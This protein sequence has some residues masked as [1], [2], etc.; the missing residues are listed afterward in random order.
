[1]KLLLSV[2]A[3]LCVVCTAN[4][5]AAVVVN[6]ADDGE[7]SLRRAVRGTGKNQ[8]VEFAPQLAKQTIL[9]KNPIVL[10]R[11]V[12]IDGAG[13][14]GVTI[15]GGKGCSAF[16]VGPRGAVTAVIRNLTVVD[17][18]PADGGGGGAIDSRSQSHLTVERCTFR[19]NAA[20]KGG[21]AI[22]CRWKH[23]TTVL[24]STFEGNVG[25]AN[26]G[27]IS[28]E[29][30]GA[31][32]IKK[33]VFNRNKGVLGGAIYSLLGALLLEDC[34]LTDNES[35]DAGG[36]VNTDGASDKTDD[37]IGG[38]ITVR[39]CRVENSKGGSQGG[40]MFLFAYKLDKI[41]VEDSVFLNNRSAEGGLGGAVRLGGL[42]EVT[43]VNSIFGGNAAGQ[44]S[45][46][47]IGDDCFGK[48]EKCTFFQNMAGK[49][50]GKH[51]AIQN[52]AKGPVASEGHT[53]LN[54]PPPNLTQA[55]AGLLQ[56]TAGVP[57][58]KTAAAAAP[59]A[60]VKL[61]ASKAE[62]PAAD[63]AA[64]MK[65]DPAIPSKDAALAM[66]KQFLMKSAASG[67]K[68]ALSVKLDFKNYSECN[69]V[70]IDDSGFKVEVQGTQMPFTWRMLKDEELFNC[71]RPAMATA[72]GDVYAAWLFLGLHTKCVDAGSARNW[73]AKLQEK[74]PQQAQ[75][76]E[77][78]LQ[79]LSK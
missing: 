15:S 74:D 58:A 51:S 72:P 12:T 52:N 38:T 50:K 22:C 57:A 7:G 17:C 14:P 78:V 8:V 19:D 29:S 64:L 36:A 18:K 30:M 39:R 60:P 56:A 46:V 26:G 37:D 21:A 3:G 53:F 1:M 4:V 31:L 6:T 55:I 41:V 47:Y 27:A 13:A 62:K 42:A 65:D 24:E 75:R 70:N 73:V 79:R 69:P 67:G 68:P 28:T 5:G 10:E 23:T 77:Q 25:E 9:L 2:A 16:V 35:S 61:F 59:A 76:V 63:L 44:G 43:V 48:V 32:A 40:A 34:V 11:D 71:F 49:T 45:G 66:L 33:C 20:P 54:E